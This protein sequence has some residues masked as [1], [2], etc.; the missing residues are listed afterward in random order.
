MGQHNIDYQALANTAVNM[1]NTAASSLMNTINSMSKYPKNISNI[2]NGDSTI[3]I[4]RQENLK[5]GI[6]HKKEIITEPN[7]DKISKESIPETVNAID[8]T[9]KKN[10]SSPQQTTQQKAETPNLKS[11]NS[12]ESVK[13]LQK[14]KDLVQQPS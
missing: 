13:D 14:Q 11:S 9:V 2:S 3:D 12:N 8:S 6:H 1:T 7:G 4:K 5:R 10:C